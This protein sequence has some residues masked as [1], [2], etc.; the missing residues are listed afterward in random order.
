MPEPNDRDGRPPPN[1]SVCSH[2]GGCIGIRIGTTAYCLAHL[3]EE[4]P[5]EFKAFLTSLGPGS[6][7]D[8][9][10]TLLSSE[11]LKEDRPFR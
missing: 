1:W 3:D 4:A 10:G 11:L 9:R 5:E 6:S 8:L 2:D 7:L